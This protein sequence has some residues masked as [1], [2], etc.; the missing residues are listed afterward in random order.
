VGPGLVLNEVL[1]VIFGG[2][3]DVGPVA[4]SPIDI[5]ATEIDEGGDDGENTFEFL[6]TGTRDRYRWHGQIQVTEAGEFNFIKRATDHPLEQQNNGNWV[7]S[8]V[9]FSLACGWAN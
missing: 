2:P 4:D 5:G 7:P 6:F 3:G 1:S 8:A 9:D